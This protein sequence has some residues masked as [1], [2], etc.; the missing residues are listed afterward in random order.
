MNKK[1]KD[2]IRMSLEGVKRD[3][4]LLHGK[5]KRGVI[6]MNS[7]DNSVR[8]LQSQLNDYVSIMETGLKQCVDTYNN[9]YNIAVDE[10]KD[11]Q[12]KYDKALKTYNDA[13]AARVLASKKADD[14]KNSIPPQ[15]VERFVETSGAV[16]L[17]DG[18]NV[19]DGIVEKLL[20]LGGVVF[21][22][23]AHQLFPN[24]TTSEKGITITIII[25]NYNY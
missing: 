11:A 21:I 9:D 19:L 7:N 2:D 1:C 15:E 17:R 5:S 4:E 6:N 20:P 14:A 10:H 24:R 3:F 13:E 18:S 22:D 12:E 8:A 23:E 25:T 16:L